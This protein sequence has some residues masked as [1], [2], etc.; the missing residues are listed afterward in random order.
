VSEF[1]FTHKEK[2]FTLV[3]LMV[4]VLILSILVAIAI[5]VYR[6]STTQANRRAV[7]A[8][9]RTI[10]SAIMQYGASTEGAIPLQTDLD[11]YL[12]EWPAGPDGVE[13]D[14][15]DDGRAIISQVSTGEWFTTSD[16][17]LPIT[18]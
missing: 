15:S 8:N 4:V 3:E 7:E 1:R 11:N 2:G 6:Q 5:P 14:V 10:D 18:W 12:Q 13:Y 16:E 17:S 9:L